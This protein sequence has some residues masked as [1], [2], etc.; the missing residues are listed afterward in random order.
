VATD[1]FDDPI[2]LSAPSKDQRIREVYEANGQQMSIPDLAK[3]CVA[4]GIWTDIEL[5]LFALR[6]VREHCRR[7]LKEQDAAGL[8]KNGQTRDQDADGQPVWKTRFLWGFEDYM[9]NVQEHV[10]QRDEN[11]TIAVKLAAEGSAR[12]SQP[13]SVPPVP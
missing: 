9:L 12:Y 3:A 4:A 13:I 6:S 1:L 11:H 2:A 5:K 8:P 7:V 10:D